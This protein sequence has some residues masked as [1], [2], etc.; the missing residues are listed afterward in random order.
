M[1]IALHGVG[2]SFGPVEA[3]RDISLAIPSGEF[4]SLLGPSGC[5]KSTLLSVVAGLE[6]ASQGSV[7][8][9]GQAGMVF[10]EAA[11]FPWRT[12]I[13]NVA[14]GLEMRGDRR[15]SKSERLAR[16]ADALRLVHLSRFADSYPH[17]LSGGM[18]QRAALARALVLDPDILLMDEPFGAL[19]AQT[20]S[21]LQA[22]LLTIWERTRKT[23]LFVTHSLDEALFLSDRIVLLSA[24]PGRVVGDYWIDAPRPR[25]PRTDAALAALRSRLLAQLSH[26]IETVARAEHDTDWHAETDAPRVPPP[27]PVL[28]NVG[29]D[30]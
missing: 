5:G 29:A 20:R 4:V 7:T 21:L 28:E 22:E 26:E 16:A 30:I 18:R 2:V 11:L 12:L 13:G 23:V 1:A 17:Q 24:R 8:V 10:Q 27:P 25:D 6:T 15:L 3:A 19:D 9:T 14:F